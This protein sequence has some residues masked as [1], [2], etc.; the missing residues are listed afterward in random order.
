MLLESDKNA[1][2]KFPGRA[3][4]KKKI[5]FGWFYGTSTILSY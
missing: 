2:L 3:F 1:V 4:L 5:W